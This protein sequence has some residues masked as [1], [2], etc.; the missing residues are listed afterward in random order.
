MSLLFS[1]YPALIMHVGERVTRNL[2]VE[3]AT[4]SRDAMSKAV[5]VRLF[6]WIF[7]VMNELLESNECVARGVSPFTSDWWNRPA[8][9][10]HC[11]ITEHLTL[12]HLPSTIR[13]QI[14]DGVPCAA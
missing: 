1:F 3:H 14:S 4:D 6:A 10:L 9:G 2:D 12:R 8:L 5:Y 7:K 11:V 13:N